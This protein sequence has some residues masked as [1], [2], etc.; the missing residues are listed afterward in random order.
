MKRTGKTLT[1]SGLL[2]A[3]LF[4]SQ[5]F[6]D[7]VTILEYSNVLDITRAWKVKDVRCFLKSNALELG[8]L[9]DCLINVRYQMNTDDIPNSNDW[10]NAG[11]NRS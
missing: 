3:K 9:E 11:A 5:I 10:Y 7:P 4:G 2:P 1:L 6:R 8:F